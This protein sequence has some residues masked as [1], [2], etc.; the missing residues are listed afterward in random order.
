MSD[1]QKDQNDKK[2]QNDQKEQNDKKDVKEPKKR[3]RKK[4]CEIDSIQKLRQNKTSNGTIVIE[5]KKIDKTKTENVEQKQISFGKF[6]IIVQQPQ[7]MSSEEIRSYF[8]KKFKID[9]SDKSAKMISQDTK[10]NTI[11]EPI[12]EDCTIKKVS[13]YLKVEEKQNIK[14]EQKVSQI[15][16]VNRILSNFINAI[17]HEWPKKTDISCWWCCHKFDT[18]PIPCPVKYDSIRDRY[19]VNGVFCCWGCVA[20]YSIEKYTSLAL[21]YQLKNKLQPHN[22]DSDIYISPSRYCL[23]EFGGYMDIEQ[24]RNNSE[25]KYDIMI[26]SE[27]MEYINQDIVE[28]K[29]SMN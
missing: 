11:P 5:T 6:N 3:G 12:A 7:P 16:K 24:F 13:N 27:T 29:R 2:D 17:E 10:S 22:F 15:Y 4:M 25:A 23:K 8:D 19:N 18:M 20:A 26:S 21:V 14:K 1:T 9:E 28:I